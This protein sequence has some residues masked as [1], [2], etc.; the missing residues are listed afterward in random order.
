MGDDFKYILFGNERHY[1]IITDIH[2]CVEVF[3]MEIKVRWIVQCNRLSRDDYKVIDIR[4]T[5]SNHEARI[6]NTNNPNDIHWMYVTHLSTNSTSK[7]LNLAN[8]HEE[9]NKILSKTKHGR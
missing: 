5:G 8:R 1:L 7:R 4:G 2:D 9:A 6:Q 3:A